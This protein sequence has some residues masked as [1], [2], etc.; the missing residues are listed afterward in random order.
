MTRAFLDVLCYNIVIIKLG[1]P[2]TKV[3]G[4]TM[5]N[6]ASSKTTTTPKALPINDAASYLGVKP[7]YVRQ[8]IRKGKFKPTKVLISPESKVWRWE[9]PVDQLDEFKSTVGT[10]TRRA[11][12][13]SKFTLYATP[14][15]YEQVQ[16]IVADAKM[17]VIIERA[18]KP[19]KEEAEA[20]AVDPK[21]AVAK[22]DEA[23]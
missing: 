10:R 12:G 15:E 19:K 17:A 7:Q 23:K 3:L 14:E 5:A 16:K 8:L 18:Y 4:G 6:E 13:R 20:E 9:I 11:D 2:N 1:H 21:E 22:T